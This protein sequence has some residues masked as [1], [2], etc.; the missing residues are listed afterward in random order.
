MLWICHRVGKVELLNCPFHSFVK[1]RHLNPSSGSLSYTQSCPQKTMVASLETKKITINCY[2]FCGR[3][4][5]ITFLHLHIFLLFFFL[6]FFLNFSLAHVTMNLS[7]DLS[8][9]T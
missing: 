3:K 8:P 5:S 1:Q 2:L 9:F 7:F 4:Y 6:S